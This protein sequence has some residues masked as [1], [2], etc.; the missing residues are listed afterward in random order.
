MFL[1]K[2][3]VPRLCVI[4]VNSIVLDCWSVKL[5]RFSTLSFHLLTITD[6]IEYYVVKCAFADVMLYAYVKHRDKCLY[7]MH[8]ALM[9]LSSQSWSQPS[10]QGL[11]NHTSLTVQMET[12]HMHENSLSWEFCGWF[13]HI[14]VSFTKRPTIEGN[15]SF[16]IKG[17]VHVHQLDL[18]QEYNNRIEFS[19]KVTSKHHI[20]WVD[21]KA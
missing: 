20:E 4:Q 19:S 11:S 5:Y 9:L 10:S 7:V 15:S 21:K 3:K 17:Q 13:C 1:C 6:A 18:L 12:V 16:I 8:D 2:E 14:H